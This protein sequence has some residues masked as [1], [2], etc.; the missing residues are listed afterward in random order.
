M[1]RLATGRAELCPCCICDVDDG[2]CRGER[3]RLVPVDNTI[4]TGASITATST[5]L[6]TAGHE[7]AA[8]VTIPSTCSVGA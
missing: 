7:V 2:D 8:L 4:A 6:Q 1:G 3:R 5:A